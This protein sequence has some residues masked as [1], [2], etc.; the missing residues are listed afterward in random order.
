MNREVLTTVGG[1][2]VVG[3]VV[4]A[5]FLYGNHQRQN[6]MHAS[7]TSQH[8]PQAAKPTPSPTP[9][10]TTPGTG[11][12][13]AQQPAAQKPSSSNQTTLQGGKSS[14]SSPAA[15]PAPMPAATPATGSS[16]LPAAIATLLVVMA[17]AY[18]KSRR[19][20]YR[21]SIRPS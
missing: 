5:T 4:V 11:S 2:L 8:Q 20:L 15:K 19:S 12:T 1:L 16:P 13:P 3:I 18:R 10:A 17:G 21:A 14:G 7:Q 6:Q 9:A